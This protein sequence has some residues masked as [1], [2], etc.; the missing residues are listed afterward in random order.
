VNVL[1]AGVGNIFLGDDGF[2]VEVARRLQARTTPDGVRVAD[3][4]I[5]G[6]HLAYELLAGYDALVLIDAMPLG[7]EPGTVAVIE[8][9]LDALAAGRELAAPVVDAHSMD[10][11]V[12]LG[13]LADLGGSIERVVIVACQPAE[14]AEGIELSAPVDAAVDAAVDAVDDVVAGLTRDMLAAS[15]EE[16]H[17]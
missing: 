14:L 5:R 17:A 2:G 12:V 16:S 15:R 13:L 3:F 9:D 10:P 11:A 7:E 6:V 8:P 1:V 4:G